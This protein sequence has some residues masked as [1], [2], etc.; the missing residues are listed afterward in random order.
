MSLN[1][2][3]LELSREVEDFCKISSIGKIDA[4]VELS[5]DIQL[6]FHFRCEALHPG[7]FKGFTIEENE[8]VRGKDTIFQSHDNFRN[9]E[10][11]KDHNSSRKPD[12]S[13]SDLVGRITSSI[14]DFSKK[15]LIMEGEVF[16][17]QIAFNIMHGLISFVSLRINPNRVDE[18]NGQRFA[19]GLN[20]EELSF[21]RAPGDPDAHIIRE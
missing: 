12:S 1:K 17:K 11:N 21:V 14:Y 18:E 15:A 10:I 7:I 8:I 13:V 5:D 20:F 4:V 2:E 16:D 6:P 3:L 19:R 9:F